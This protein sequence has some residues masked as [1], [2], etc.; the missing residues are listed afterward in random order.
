M[1]NTIASPLNIFRT[2]DIISVSLVCGSSL[3]IGLMS[4]NIVEWIEPEEI[5]RTLQGHSDWINCLLEC[6]EMLWSGSIDKT[7][8]VWNIST[9]ES[10]SKIQTTSSVICLVRWRETIISGGYKYPDGDPFLYVWRR[11]GEAINNWKLEEEG[12][13]GNILDKQFSLIPQ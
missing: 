3:F 2:M 10:I 7:I 9:G 5:K 1:S 13:E 8:I 6:G 12:E 11:Y 4:G